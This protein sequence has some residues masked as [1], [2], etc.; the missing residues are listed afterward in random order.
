MSS[1]TWLRAAALSGAVVLLVHLPAATQPRAGSKHAVLVGVRTYAHDSL[2]DLKHTERDVEELAKVLESSGYQV[3]LLT[4]TRGKKD[5]GAAPTAKNIRVALKKVLDRVNKH[6][7]VLVGLAGHGL[8][9]SVDVAGK[10]KDK[11]FFCPSDARPRDTKDL[12]LLSETMI[13]LD[14]L[15]HELEQSGAG[16]KLLLVDAC[17]NDPTIGRSLDVDALPRPPRGTAALFSC[18]SGER[19]FETDK[20][21]GG[22]G[23]FFFH[24]LQGLKGEARNRRGEVTWDRL[25][26]YVKEQVSDDVPRLIGGGARQTPHDIKNLTGKSPV[27]VPP[28]KE[29]VKAG[30]LATGKETK[31]KGKPAD[32]SSSVAGEE[33]VKKA[34]GKAKKVEAGARVVVRVQ[35]S[36]FN[37]D[38]GNASLAVPIVRKG[39]KG[40]VIAVNETKNLCQLRLDDPADEEV[41]V[42]LDKVVAE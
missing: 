26:E 5:A 37:D 29:V 7:T 1:R 9:F 4:S 18:K 2:P 20:L 40:K 12:K 21:G 33:K 10:E 24:V 25:A 3:T 27:L 31:T 34:P 13:G 6:D 30:A 32:G 42:G 14:E 22:H 28:G 8:Q 36:G 15:F 11:S 19:A 38:E 41:W 35:T 17:R 23:V 16:V 39:T